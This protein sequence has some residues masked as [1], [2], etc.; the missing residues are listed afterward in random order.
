MDELKDLVLALSR[1]H[2]HG[3][4]A[5][6]DAI[7]WRRSS[8]FSAHA[9]RRA[10]P[11]AVAKEM[12]DILQVDVAGFRNCVV[13]P[14][15]AKDTADLQ[16]L[17]ALPGMEVRLLCRIE[18][19][20]TARPTAALQY[21]LLHV[22]LKATRRFVILRMRS[23]LAAT[24]LD[25]VQ[26][27][28]PPALPVNNGKLDLLHEFQVAVPD[29]AADDN[30]ESRHPLADFVLRAMNEQWQQAAAMLE[31]AL[32]GTDVGAARR[33]RRVPSQSYEQAKLAEELSQ[34]IYQLDLQEKS[35]IDATA[36]TRS[37]LLV[38]VE[39][40]ATNNNVLHIPRR[41]LTLMPQQLLAW[42][43]HFLRGTAAFELLY[44]GPFQPVKQ[45]LETAA[46]SDPSSASR[47]ELL[48]I[49]VTALRSLQ[50]TVVPELRLAPR[51]AAD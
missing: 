50:Q 27:A 4:A 31:H 14:W 17:A 41:L 37:G 39:I 8:L 20:A 44:D 48:A 25:S 26:P 15:L 18:P 2:T 33:S 35:A 1:L 34:A 45:A 29:P 11:D 51:S 23:D 12:A 32:A 46:E 49:S 10:L 47:D 3:A 6:A 36:T 21:F 40:R 5:L 30:L 9:G 7:G 13:E 38:T 16:R 42:K 22:Q 43:A 28:P 24:W 19:S